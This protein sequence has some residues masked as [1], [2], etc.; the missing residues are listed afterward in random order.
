MTIQKLGGMILGLI[1]MGMTSALPARVIIVNTTNNVSPDSNETNLVQALSL[2]QDGD[3]IHFN[4]P[5]RGPFYLVTPPRSPDNGYPPITNNNITI[6]G[7]SQPG[8]FAN[9][10]TIL[11]SNT[12]QIQIVLDSRAGGERVE[13]LSGLGTNESSVLLVK[14]A[15]NVT[16]RGLDFLGPGIGSPDMPDDP[17]TYAISFA[18]GATNGHVQGCWFGVAPDRTNVFRFCEAVTGFQGTNGD[19]SGT[20]VGV[21]KNAPDTATARGQFNVIVGEYIAIGLEGSDFRIAGNFIN[22]FPDG[23]T[24]Y[25][26]NGV[27]DYTLQAFIEIGRSG[28]NLVLGT[29][30]DGH[31]DAEER[32][33]FGGVIYC[34]DSYQ[35]EWY[36]C[37]SSNT[38]IAGNYFGVGVD[39]LTRF[40][41]SMTLLGGL[42]SSTTLQFGSDFDGVSDTLEGNVISLNY[43]FDALFPA[44]ESTSPS[45]PYAFSKVQSGAIISFR[46][47]ILMGAELMPFTYANG[48]GGY[49][50]D[51]V[52][53]YTNYISVPI[54]P[55]L[56]PNST[57]TLLKG[58][59]PAGVAPFTNIVVDVYLADDEAWTN[60]QLFQFPE[61]AYTHPVTSATEYY[62]F[63]EG[64]TWLASFNPNSPANL[65]PTPG[66]FAFDIS[67]L[68]L[69]AD[70]LVTV[71]ASYS[72]QTL[73]THNAVMHTSPFALPVIP[74]IVPY[75]GITVSGG[76][77]SLSW[78]TNAG[79]FD[80]LT[81]PTLSP[82]AWTDLH[83]QP[84]L[85]V[86]GTNYQANISLSGQAGFFRL[87]R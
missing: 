81:S 72:A 41:N 86:S 85:L 13:C 78:P 70:K 62:G 5:G 24:D 50:S 57:Q 47:N 1:F 74:Q 48:Y 71:A 18:V 8:A 26:I 40:T 35:L 11:G 7:Y 84:L 10:N 79:A 83:P 39:G 14:G 63:A 2:A 53:Y 6:D 32:N 60:G 54:F 65:D 58:T 22:V 64:K 80:I 34:E 66:Q 75:L 46:G 17:S 20:V 87:S 61:L 44:P 55:T 73:G 43:P 49:L 76:Y 51:F 36:G 4:I 23:L 67:A 28:D 45:N 12:A 29:D 69:P 27:D 77:V 30:G 31:N 19:A 33:I 68:N 59:I 16:I 3:A 42:N 21:E 82:P 56:S 52:Q 15:T 38:V 37:T 9:T 25:N